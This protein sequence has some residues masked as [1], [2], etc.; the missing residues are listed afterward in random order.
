MPHS[1]IEDYVLDNPL[2]S[3]VPELDTVVAISRINSC[4][5]KKKKLAFTDCLYDLDT[6]IKLAQAPYE[7]VLN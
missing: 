1:I 3:V 7:E 5:N 2:M 6:T 4:G